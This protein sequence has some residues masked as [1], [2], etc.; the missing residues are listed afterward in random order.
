M[1]T[2]FPVNDNVFPLVH[3]AHTGHAQRN[4]RRAHDVSGELQSVSGDMQA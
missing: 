1:C 4:S 2:A 3:K